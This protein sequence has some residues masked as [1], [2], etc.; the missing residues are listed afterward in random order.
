MPVDYLHLT[1]DD[2]RTERQQL[3]AAGRDVTPIERDFD[4]LLR[5]PAPETPN[6][7]RQAETLLDD[8]TELPLR[9]EYDYTE[10]NRLAAIRAARPDESPVLPEK[11]T[12]R[13][14]DDR[15]AGAWIGRCAGCLLGKPV[16]RW[17]GPEIHSFLHPSGQ[18]PL[19]E[20]IRSDVPSA[21]ANQYQMD[22]TGGFI[23]EIDQMPRDDDLDFTVIALD[24]VETYGTEFQTADLAS[25]WLTEFPV[26]RL[27]TAERVAYRNLCNGQTA[28]T[29]ATTRNPYRELIGAQIRADLYGWVHPGQPAKAATL[30]WR[31]ARLSHVQNGLYGAMWVAAM[32]AATPVTDSIPRLIRSGLAEIPANSRLAAAITDVLNWYDAGHE[33]EHAIAAIRNEWNED[34]L[35]GKYHTIS[36]AQIVASA[37]LWGTGFSDSIQRAVQVGFDTDCNGATVGSLIGLRLGQS[38]LPDRWITP[39]NGRL[40]TALSSYAEPLIS[41]LVDR[42]IPLVDA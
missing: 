21:I 26:G 7:Q 2:L 20:Y 40:R 16:E 35:Y 25:K 9:S 27:Y 31:D 6:W 33:Y 14:L 29:T 34:S 28:P 19:T 38:A 10:P 37:L 15:I 1:P 32:L 17:T 41:E 18:Y 36:N 30:A 24:I 42:T 13:L 23:N 39:L 8:A 5:S 3:L 12:D 11:T 4:S 22:A